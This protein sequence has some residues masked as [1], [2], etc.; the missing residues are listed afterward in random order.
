MTAS[1][2]DSLFHAPSRRH[3]IQAVAA[4]VAASALPARSQWR[5][6]R[7]IRLVIPYAPGGTTDLIA[8]IVAAPLG[9]DLVQDVIVDNKPGGGATI[10]MAAVAQAAPDGYT[11]GI[12]AIGAHAANAT[13]MAKLPYDTE[14][15]F[16]SIVF[17]GASPLVLVANAANPATSVSDLLARA[18]STGKV[19]NFASGGIGLGSHIAG[20]L[21]KIRSGADMTHIAYKGGG[22]AMADV[23]GGQVD[24]LFAPVGTVLP[25][26]NAGKLKALAIANGTRSSRMPAVPTFEEAGFPDFVMAESF[27]LIGPKGLPMDV[28][29]RLNQATTSVLRQPDVVKR[30]EEQGVDVAPS[31]PQH[32]DAFIRGEVKKYREAIQQAGIKLN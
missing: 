26:V 4:I 20:E 6:Q 13:L 9:L 28:V 10:G 19:V 18:K 3:A 14:R 21:L 30:L 16:Q 25:F 8:R 5:P 27:G 32:L 29:Q 22:P 24:I 12:P 31:T 17:I 23:V 2:Q 11:L 7:P 1:G 15:D